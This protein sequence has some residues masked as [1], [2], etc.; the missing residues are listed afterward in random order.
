MNYTTCKK[1]L[2]DYF[3]NIT[4]IDDQFDQSLI[5]EPYL[6]EDTADEDVPLPLEIT[7]AFIPSD[8]LP[9]GGENAS[10][11]R[12]TPEE[13][14]NFNLARVL[15]ALNDRKYNDVRLNPVYYTRET[16]RGLL[17]EKVQTAPLTIIDW[18]LG[19]GETAFP[20]IKTLFDTTKRLKV[21]VVYTSDF[22]GAVAA[23][24]A[25]PQLSVY[26]QLQTSNEQFDCYKC[27]NKSLLIIA[28]KQKYNLLSLLDTVPDLFIDNCGLMPAAL[29]D[30]MESAQKLSGELFGAFCQPFEDMYFLQMYFSELYELDVP[31]TLATFIQNKFRE[32]CSIDSRIANELFLYQRDRLAALLRRRDDEACEVIQTALRA[33]RPHLD[34]EH[35]NF[36]DALMTIEYASFKGYC[37]HAIAESENWGE[38]LLGFDGMLEEVKKKVCRE[39]CEKL[40]E[41]YSNIDIPAEQRGELVHHRESICALF[42]EQLKED[43][44]AFKNQVFPIV[45]QVLISSPS[46]LSAGPELVRNL[47]YSTHGSTSLCDLLNEGKALNKKKREAFLM[48]K[49]HFGD[50]LFK[51]NGQGKVYLLCITPPCDAF[52]PEKTKLNINFIKGTEIN[53][54]DLNIRRKDSIHIS[55]L[56]VTNGDHDCLKYIGWKLYDIVKFDMNENSD[57]D[58]LCTYTRPF[59]MSEQYVRQ[60]ANQFTAYFSRAGVDEIFMKAENNLRKMF[61]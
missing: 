9:E 51:D 2:T 50:V 26:T 54:R 55:A 46:I 39:K 14:S 7:D 10:D 29:L 18:N 16:E 58:E 4:Y 5:N 19:G 33:L 52:R 49:I 20:V 23:L 25:D 56:P 57:Y 42:S 3:G 17:L 40:F 24:K 47:K 8:N 36:C 38:V 34:G 43:F 11:Y 13:R 15:I 44:I 37:G 59:I 48:N 27:D 6:G 1:K 21:V 31:D 28:S 61:T 45:I 60:I 53:Y 22:T 35:V 41:P 32:D 12:L 30:Y